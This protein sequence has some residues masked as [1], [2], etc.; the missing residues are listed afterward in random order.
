MAHSFKIKLA[1]LLPEKATLGIPPCP[2]PTVH[3]CPVR[4]N[5]LIEVFAGEAKG[6]ICFTV[7]AQQ[8]AEP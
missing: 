7:E 4:N 3:Q 8:H 1:V 5:P 2:L 6:L